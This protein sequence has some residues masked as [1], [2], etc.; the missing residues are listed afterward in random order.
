MTGGVH[1]FRDADGNLYVRYFYWN[2]GAW[3]RDYNWLDNDWNRQNPAVELATLFISLPLSCR[4]SF[5]LLVCHAI[6]Q[7]CDP[8]QIFFQKERYIF[9]YP[10]LLF[11]TEP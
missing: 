6:R 1:T 8:L 5:L 7:S 2:G 11:P 3:R 9:C 10:R 4:E